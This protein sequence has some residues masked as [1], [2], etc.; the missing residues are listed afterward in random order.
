[1][2]ERDGEGQDVRAARTWPPTRDASL[3]H[4]RKAMPQAG[5]IAVTL[6]EVEGKWPAQAGGRMA[7]QAAPR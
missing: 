5:Q 6:S 7:R 1:M 3:K 2:R 4:Q